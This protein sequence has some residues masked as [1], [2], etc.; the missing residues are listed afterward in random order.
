MYYYTNWIQTW[1]ASNRK[2]GSLLMLGREYQWQRSQFLVIHPGDRGRDKWSWSHKHPGITTVTKINPHLL[3]R[4]NPRGDGRGRSKWMIAHLCPDAEMAAQVMIHNPWIPKG[5]WVHWVP[6]P[7]FMY[8]SYALHQEDTHSKSFSCYD[9]RLRTSLRW[10]RFL[11]PCKYQLA[12]IPFKA[13]R[14]AELQIKRE[15]STLCLPW[16]QHK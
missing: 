4:L 10:E 2:K 16:D 12:I 9:K 8:L 15:E 11:S 6:F 7:N 5:S 1:C 13:E 14:T 3:Q